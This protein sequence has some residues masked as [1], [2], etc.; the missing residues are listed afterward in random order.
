[1]KR[2]ERHECLL[3]ACRTGVCVETAEVTSFTQY[4]PKVF[5]TIRNC[6]HQHLCWHAQQKPPD[7]E[8]NVVVPYRHWFQSLL[9]HLFNKKVLEVRSQGVMVP[10]SFSLQRCVFP[11]LKR[12]V[13]VNPVALIREGR[14][15]A[16]TDRT[17][18]RSKR[19][20][21]PRPA[22]SFFFT[23]WKVRAHCSSLFCH[24]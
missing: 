6:R 3:R 21:W 17:Q 5:S 23:C 13:E 7:L 9:S 22:C 14:N 8:I 12:N 1:M 11:T 20:Q 2:K 16:G 18:S 19:Y 4:F 10:L 24:F 15:P